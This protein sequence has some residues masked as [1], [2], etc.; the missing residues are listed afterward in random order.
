MQFNWTDAATAAARSSHAHGL[1]AAETAADLERTFGGMLSRNAV[2]GKWFRMGLGD[3]EKD[4]HARA[5]RRSRRPTRA[6]PKS[7]AVRRSRNVCAPSLVPSADGAADAPHLDQVQVV[8]RKQLL[9]LGPGDC[10]WPVGDPKEPDFFFCGATQLPGSSYC[11][12]HYHVA[13]APLRRSTLP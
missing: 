11:R 1:S 2:L 13:T 3:K 10:R 8:Q 9:D 7:P 5:A 4:N 12:R 6:K